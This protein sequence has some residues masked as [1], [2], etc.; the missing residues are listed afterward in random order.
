MLYLNTKHIEEMGVNW[1][2]TIHVI[3][4]AVQNYQLGHYSQPI[5]PYLRFKDLTNRII[6][7]PAYI[8]GDFESVGLKW[9]ASF[10]KNIEQGIQRAHSVNLINDPDTGKLLATLH[11]AIVSGIRTASVSGL[12]I[13][14]CEKIRHLHEIKL[15][16]IGFGPIGQLHL[17][18]LILY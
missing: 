17:Q 9:I 10:P 8:G 5:K 3:R 2:E 11:T 1:S 7:M 16:I 6:A 12:I 14:E 18:M 15:G 4:D 13:Q